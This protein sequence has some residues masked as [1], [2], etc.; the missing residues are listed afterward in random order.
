MK[1]I[2]GIAIGLVMAAAGAVTFSIQ[3]APS[4]PAVRALPRTGP[5]L[6][7]VA[8]T[9][10]IMEGLAQANFRGLEGLLK[11]KP[12]DAEGWKF[13]RGQ[14][15]LIAETGNLLMLR[16]PRNP[17]EK[18]WMDRATQLRTSATQLARS[19]AARDHEKSRQGLTTVA[20]SCNACH[21]AFRV[22][23]RIVPFE[24][25]EDIEDKD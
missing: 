10:L 9:K 15:L 6:V 20:N 3:A 7:P 5:K 23:M 1:L 13:A 24:A 17:G 14:A 11:E 19:L 22:K 25:K 4:G 18:A 16:P 2:C 21:K 8:E 12:K